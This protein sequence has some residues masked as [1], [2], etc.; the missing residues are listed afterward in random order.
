M[1]VSVP[2]IKNMYL[3]FMKSLFS[4]L[5]KYIKKGSLNF[6]EMEFSLLSKQLV[7]FFFILKNFSLTKINYLND[8][9]A[10]DYFNQKLNRFNVKY[11]SSSFNFNFKITLS[12]FLKEYQAINTLAN[13]FKSSV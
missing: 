4:Y 3:L 13:T 2:L 9:V 6:P 1:F 7:D 11:I 8:I 10:L 5:P 12:V